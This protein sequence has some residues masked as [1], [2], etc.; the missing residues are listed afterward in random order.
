MSTI[1][2]PDSQQIDQRLRLEYLE[3]VRTNTAAK[4]A[5]SEASAPILFPTEA[6]QHD[7]RTE[8][9]LNQHFELLRQQKRHAQLTLLKDEFEASFAS[10]G[11]RLTEISPT[12][13]ESSP[14]AVLSKNERED[15]SKLIDI[16][17]QALQEALV[18]AH[19]NAEREGALLLSAKTLMSELNTTTAEIR[20]AAMS[21]ARTELSAWLEQRLDQ[22][23][24]ESSLQV[25]DFQTEENEGDWD[26]KI[27]GA[28][29]S[30]LEA[31]KR[32][33]ASI[34]ELKTPTRTTEPEKITVR[35]GKTMEQPRLPPA[36]AR[37]VMNPVETRLVQTLLHKKLSHAHFVSATEQ[38]QNELSITSNMLD[39]LREESQLLQAF[40]MLS[41]SGRFRHI[42]V[43]KEDENG[44][45]GMGETRKQLEPW[46]F[47]AEAAEVASAGTIEKHLQQG[48]EAVKEVSRN[49]AELRLLTE[50]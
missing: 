16:H 44:G 27:D 38:L 7:E 13:D 18:E 48:S 28:Y 34:I 29:E 42:T 4:H 12:A 24:D 21:A 46:L 19:H 2:S 25:D 32:L 37:D 43:K 47:A 30:Y 9:V 15:C 8:T 40:P 33:I 26:A 23:Q 36:E 6:L 5:F 22:C 39:R 14:H 1:D 17:V 31:R 45:E 20:L 11:L 50:T 35:R 41:H 49:L 3:A 10:P